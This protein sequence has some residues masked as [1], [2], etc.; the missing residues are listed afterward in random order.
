MSPAFL[1]SIHKK[2]RLSGTT[3]GSFSALSV[4]LVAAAGAGD[5]DAALPLR[6]AAHRAALGAGEVAVVLIHPLLPVSGDA[7]ADGI[8]NLFHKAGV[9]RPALFQIAGKHTVQRQ[10][11]NDCG[12][13]TQNAVHRRLLVPQENVDNIQQQRRPD[14]GQAEAV[15]TVTAIH[16]TRKRVADALEEVHTV[17]APLLILLTRYFTRKVSKG[18]ELLRK[19]HKMDKILQPQAAVA[20][21]ITV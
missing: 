16:K 9:L 12:N 1:R 8:P 15:D 14:H 21:V 20:N 10:K 11:Y 13:E 3:S 2:S 5:D 4:Y 7:A 6:H 19:I 18:K 17:K